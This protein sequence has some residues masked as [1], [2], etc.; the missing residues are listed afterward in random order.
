MCFRPATISSSIE[1]PECGKKVR[2]V[3]GQYPN[4]CPFCEADISALVAEAMADADPATGA[5]RSAFVSAPGAPAAPPAP[6]A[7][8]PPAAPTTPKA[9]KSE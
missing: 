6:G 7:P 1:C 2:E 9:S 4:Q 3:L 5:P 8:T